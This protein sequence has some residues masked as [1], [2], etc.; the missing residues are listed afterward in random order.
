[1]LKEFG[2][3]GEFAKV[4][5]CDQ[6]PL[7]IIEAITDYFKDIDSPVIPKS[8]SSACKRLCMFLRWMIRDNSPVDLGLWSEFAD[9]RKLIIPMDTHV[10]TQARRLGLISSRTAS[11]AAA[12][13]LSNTL[14]TVFPYD[15]M[16]GD[17]ALFGYGVSVGNDK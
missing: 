17:F 5:V 3:I 4:K 16:K 6:N 12:I 15:P 14:A 1:M 13:K 9:K 2:S 8:T 7:S 11:M 10:L